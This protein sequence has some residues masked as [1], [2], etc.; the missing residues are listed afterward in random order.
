MRKNW[1]MMVVLVVVATCTSGAM[2]DWMDN[3]T[4]T[5]G[6]A[7]NAAWVPTTIGQLDGS[8]FAYRKASGFTYRALGEPA[9]DVI[10]EF[11]FKTVGTVAGSV[12]IIG[13]GDTE[14]DNY[15]QVEIRTAAGTAADELKFVYNKD[16]TYYT[17]KT[18]SITQDTLYDVRIAAATTASWWVTEYKESSSST[19]ISG[20]GSTYVSGVDRAFM[21]FFSSGDVRVDKIGS[22]PE[23][24]TLGILAVGGILALV[25]RRRR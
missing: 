13:L 7:L 17:M 9:A 12:G 25:R 19:W 3:F 1:L 22:V 11:T 20:G 15:T 21:A 10:L 14:V 4:G 2:A 24:V 6:S 5:A 18:V 8:G 23:P 16:G